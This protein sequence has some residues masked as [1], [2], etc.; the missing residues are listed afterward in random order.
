MKAKIKK[1][2]LNLDDIIAIGSVSLIVLCTVF[3]VFMR[4][5]VGNPLKWT[6]EVSLA[7]VVWFV[8][9]G[10]SSAMKRD[11]HISIDFFVSLV[12]KKIR[13]Y[14]DVFVI[15]V[16][17]IVLTIFSILGFQLSMKAGMKITPILKLPYTY[18]D[19]AI[20][21]GSILMVV[22]L[23]MKLIS[24]KDNFKCKEE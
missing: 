7:L 5:V 11:Q 12:P 9:F 14:I 21:F 6:E 8:F 23:I 16:N 1:I 20:T 10:A 19:I 18:I 3:G 17:F 15:I 22:N 4:Y 2:L 24:T 13:R